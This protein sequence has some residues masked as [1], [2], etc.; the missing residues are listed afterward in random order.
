MHIKRTSDKLRV[1]R[2]L[3]AGREQG[4]IQPRESKLAERHHDGFSEPRK[5]IQLQPQA[6]GQEGKGAREK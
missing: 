4:Q 2:C 6:S 5:R 1:E 3:G